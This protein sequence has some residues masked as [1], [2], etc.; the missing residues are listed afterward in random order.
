[1]PRQRYATV[2][3]QHVYIMDRATR[4]LGY[5]KRGLVAV[6]SLETGISTAV[7]REMLKNISYKYPRKSTGKVRKY[8]GW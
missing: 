2:A 6:Q 8:H 4:R 5:K 7:K 1:M 3:G